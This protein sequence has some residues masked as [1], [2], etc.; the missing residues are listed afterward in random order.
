[1]KK[2]RILT[3]ADLDAHDREELSKDGEPLE[4]VS[5]KNIPSEIAT[6]V[7]QINHIT[8]PLPELFKSKSVKEMEKA[9]EVIHAINTNQ[10]PLKDNMTD[11]L[12]SNAKMTEC[13]I[14]VKIPVFKIIDEEFFG[15]II[16]N[17]NIDPNDIAESILKININEININDL[18]KEAILLKFKNNN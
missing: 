6:P 16:K 2:D 4:V 18:I 3:M 9:N 13:E 1:M 7:T 11:I 12:I 17:M 14:F 15:S 5:H 10:S 8:S